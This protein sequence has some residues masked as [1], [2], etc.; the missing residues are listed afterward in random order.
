MTSLPRIFWP[1]WAPYLS[2]LIACLGLAVSP[3]VHAQA[4][5]HTLNPGANVAS[6]VSAAAAGATVCLNSGN[7]GTQTFSGIVKSPRVTIRSVTG[8]GASM[9]IQVRS[10]TNGL[11]FDSV[12]FT[13][14]NQVNGSTIANLTFQNSKFDGAW[15]YLL[16]LSKSNILLTNNTHNNTEAGGWQ[17]MSCCRIL[18]ADGS[19]DS[20]VTVQNSVI[21]GG[22]ADGI[23]VGQ[24]MV[25][26]NNEIMNIRE[27][28][29][30]GCHTDGIQ[31]YGGSSV[32]IRNNYIHNTETAIA[33]FDGGTNQLI[34]NNIIDSPRPWGSS[35][36]RTRILLSGTTLSF[37]GPP[38]ALSILNAD[39][40][41]STPKEQRDLVLRSTTTLLPR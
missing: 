18:V 37:T 13:G 15:I 2:V 11:T 21:D 17:V 41:T 7:Y 29:T 12:T 32:V 22:S 4:C 38:I 20:G 6:T 33:Q 30:N 1:C 31:I 5:T 14:E 9:N 34:E 24:Q 3:T 26:Q 25:I 8:Q 27:T 16:N 36:M 40:S 39:R 35:S 28:C 10:G 23:Q 19:G